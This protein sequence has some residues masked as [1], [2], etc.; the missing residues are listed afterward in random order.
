MNKAPRDAIPMP[1]DLR[2]RS[3]ADS[4]AL[5]N[6]TTLAWTRALTPKADPWARPVTNCHVFKR[7]YLLL[8]H[9]MYHQSWWRHWDKHRMPFEVWYTV[10]MRNVE[11]IVL[12]CYVKYKETI[13]AELYIPGPSSV[14]LPNHHSSFSVDN[15]EIASSLCMLFRVSYRF[16][17]SIKI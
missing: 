2:Q 6:L 10:F 3:A 11:L 4:L 5:L 7:V 16:P 8:V 14:L 13:F 12:L 17:K 9:S 15:R 1:Y